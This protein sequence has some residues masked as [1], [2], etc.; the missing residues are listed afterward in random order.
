MNETRLRELLREVAVP[1]EE[2]AERRGLA[3]AEAAFAER[4]PGAVRTGPESR[5]GPASLSRLAIALALFTLLAAL[6]LSPAG[7]AVRDWVDEVF[8]G[9]PKPEPGLAEIPGGGRLLVESAQ[10]PWIVQPN[11]SRRLLGEFGQA[12]WSPR[13]LFVATV[14]GDT[15][16]ALEPD[17]TPRWSL[18]TGARVADPRWSPSGYRIAYR[19]GAALRV[20]A[21]DGS[22]DR[23]IDQ[24]VAPVAPAWAPSGQNQLAFVDADGELRIADTDRGRT[25]GAGLVP[26]RLLALEWAG[27]LILE[28][29]A[30]TLELRRVEQAKLTGGARVGPARIGLELPT[31]S[32]VLDAALA[33]D[34][35]RIA[36]TVRLAGRSRERSAVLLYALGPNAAPQR[37][38]TL[39][40]SLPELT[41]APDSSRLLV[42]WPSADQWLFLPVGATAPPRALSGI[43]AAFAPGEPDAAFPAVEG[44]CCHAR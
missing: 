3:L 43:A 28:A 25:T 2:S 5:R 40:G 31:G 34:G 24:A 35:S 20:T 16:S 38:L 26:P 4:A 32:E 30:S 29:S 44:W 12:S 36:A 22:G 14:A 33:P 8:T 13:G 39:P 6:L 42:A 18:S 1:G 27:A 10:G 21:A 37:L 17:G 41:W 7:A 15:L 9:A 11:G 19:S 23:P